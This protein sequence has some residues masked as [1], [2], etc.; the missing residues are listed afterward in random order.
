MDKKLPFQADATTCL[1][2]DRKRPAK[3]SPVRQPFN[4]RK[5]KVPYITEDI[6]GNHVA[7][8]TYDRFTY[9][10][11]CL[12]SPQVMDCAMGGDVYAPWNKV[13]ELPNVTRPNIQRDADPRQ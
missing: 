10:Q 9:D 1:P 11:I 6:L 3:E 5:N 13:K 7:R 12:I 2:D 4:K 8:L